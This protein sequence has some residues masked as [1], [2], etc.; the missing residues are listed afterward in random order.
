MTRDIVIGFVCVFVLFG[1]IV[2]GWIVID[3]L[4]KLEEAT[5]ALTD[6]TPIMLCRS[7]ILSD[8]SCTRVTFGAK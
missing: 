7:G 6:G 1:N 2:F 3:R 5:R 4:N 8:Q